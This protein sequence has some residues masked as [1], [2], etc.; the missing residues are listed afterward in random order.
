MLGSEVVVVRC[1]ALDPPGKEVE[2]R[3]SA[4]VLLYLRA[5][6]S[7]VEAEAVARDWQRLRSLSVSGAGLEQ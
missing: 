2:R 1:S 3:T 5:A 6:S 4:W 7:E